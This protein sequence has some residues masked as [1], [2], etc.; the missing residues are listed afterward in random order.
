MYIHTQKKKKNL[1]QAVA[2]GLLSQRMVLQFKKGVK[3]ANR[4]EYLE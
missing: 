4:T 1:T 3:I 2:R